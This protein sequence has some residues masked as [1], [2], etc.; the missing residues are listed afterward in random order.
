MRTTSRA[1]VLALLCTSALLG[2]AAD[3]LPVASAGGNSELAVTLAPD[4]GRL[5]VRTRERFEILVDN[6]AGADVSGLRISL[7]GRG[8]LAALSLVEAPPDTIT[9]SCTPGTSTTAGAGPSV[10]GCTATATPPTC[11]SARATLT[12][13]YAHMPLQPAGTPNAKLLLVISAHTGGRGTEQL[14]AS[15]TGSLGNSVS[16]HAQV[17]ARFSVGQ[18]KNPSG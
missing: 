3:T 4:H 13:S 11:A 10:G 5:P 18:S 17:R 15:A 16:L 9:M 6:R 2:S 1:S 14:L 12:C 7:E 8:G